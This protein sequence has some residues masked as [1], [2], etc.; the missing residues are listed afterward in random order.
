MQDEN[1]DG[2]AGAGGY[3]VAAKTV[4]LRDDASRKSI[5]TAAA[6]ESIEAIAAKYAYDGKTVKLSRDEVRQRNQLIREIRKQTQMTLKEIGLLFG[7]LSESMVGK[8]VKGD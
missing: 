4:Q 6:P 8:I 5:S 2:Y 3:G 1:T 7:G